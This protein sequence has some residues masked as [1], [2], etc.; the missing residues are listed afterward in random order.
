MYNAIF[1]TYSLVPTWFY[2]VQDNRVAL[3]IFLFAFCKVLGPLLLGL[4]FNS[5]GRR[6]IIS[7]TY[8]VTGFDLALT[9][10]FFVAAGSAL[11]LWL[12]A[13]VWS[14]LSRPQCLA[15]PI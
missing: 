3:Y 15:P 4:F 14:F 10:C 11:S 9:G 1:F 12:V 5:L 7:L 8:I 6:L 2:A 13:G